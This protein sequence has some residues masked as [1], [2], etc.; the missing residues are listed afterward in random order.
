MG[1]RVNRVVDDRVRHRVRRWRPS[2]ASSTPPRPARST[3]TWASRRCSRRSSRRSSA[4]SAVSSGAVL[5]AYV[6]AFLEVAARRRSSASPTSSRPAPSRPRCTTSST[7]SCPA[8]LASYRDAFVFVFLILDAAV[9]AQR[10][11]GAAARARRRRERS[12]RVRD[13][14]DPAVAAW[15]WRSLLLETFGGASFWQGLGDHARHLRRS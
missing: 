9:P 12:P 7:R 4:A 3:R 5:G 2:R 1:I 8:T 11:A 6:L 10:P 14:V 15:S 13:G